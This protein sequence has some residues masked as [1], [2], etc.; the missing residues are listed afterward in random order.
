MSGVVR[1]AFGI[2]GI[3]GDKERI[4]LTEHEHGVLAGYDG[5]RRRNCKIQ[6]ECYR[7]DEKRTENDGRKEATR[8]NASS[9]SERCNQ[10]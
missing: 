7:T 4:V 3:R 9:V 5:M 6:T 8:R 1:R 10:S 2:N